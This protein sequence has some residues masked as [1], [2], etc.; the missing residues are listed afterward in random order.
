MARQLQVRLSSRSLLTFVV[1]GMV[2]CAI[3]PL[4]L[5]GWAGWFHNP[6]MFLLAPIQ[7]PIRSGV[8]ALRG[9]GPA[10]LA[11]PLSYQSVDQRDE[12]V[13]QL[14]QARGE[15]SD[16]RTQIRELSHGLELNPGLNVL[17]LIAPVIGT[18]GDSASG[19]FS[20]KAGKRDGVDAGCVVAVRGVHLIG[21]VRGADERTA[22]VLPITD[23]AAGKLI[24]VVMLDEQQLGP[25][26]LLEPVG[27]GTLVGTVADSGD[28]SAPSAANKPEVG[29]TVRLRDPQWAASAQMLIIG[30][31]ERVQADAKQPLLKTAIV[32]RPQYQADRQRQVIVRVPDA[33]VPARDPQTGRQA[34]PRP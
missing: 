20:V 29:L 10:R 26:C 1:W 25:A 33:A 30:T 31:I 2:I 4:K 21:R 34:E 19:V 22:A 27:D 5:I 14:L 15:I 24:G 9:D 7:H 3:A 8:I 23:K 28:P 18:G 11:D 12:L 13:Q 32:V 16:L 17:Q 6:V